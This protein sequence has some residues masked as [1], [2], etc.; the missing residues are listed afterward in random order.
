M[1]RIIEKLH[2]IEIG[3]SQKI[4]NVLRLALL[5]RARIEFRQ[6]LFGKASPVGIFQTADLPHIVLV[7]RR[8]ILFQPAA[9]HTL[10][11]AVY[12]RSFDDLFHRFL[13]E[14]G[15]ERRKIVVRTQSG[16]HRVV[17]AADLIGFCG[18]A[19]HDQIV[20]NAFF[21]HAA[22]FFFEQVFDQLL[23]Y[24]DREL[25]S[26]ETQRVQ[27]IE[28]HKFAVQQRVLRQHRRAGVGAFSDQVFQ[29]GRRA[30]V[31]IHNFFKIPR[32]GF[33]AGS[34]CFLSPLCPTAFQR[35]DIIRHT[36]GKHRFDL[37]AHG[38]A[39]L[40]LFEQERQIRR[41]VI[42]NFPQL[43]PVE[44]IR[45]DA[46]F[47]AGQPRKKRLLLDLRILR[48]KRMLRRRL[49]QHRLEERA[50][51]FLLAGLIPALRTV[52][53]V[54]GIVIRELRV[55]IEYAPVFVRRRFSHIVFQRTKV[56]MV[57]LILTDL[58]IAEI[59]FA[60][61]HFRQPRRIK[62][63]FCR[64]QQLH[65]LAQRRRESVK[66]GVQIVAQYDARR[67]GI[68]ERLIVIERSQLDFGPR[69]QI[70]QGLNICAALL[71]LHRPPQSG[72]QRRL[73]LGYAHI[74][75]GKDREVLRLQSQLHIHFR[76]EILCQLLHRSVYRRAF[77]AVLRCF[78]KE[79][80]AVLDDM[81][82]RQKY[83]PRVVRLGGMHQFAAQVVHRGVPAQIIPIRKI[84]VIE[85]RVFPG[86][87]CLIVRKE[88]AFMQPSEKERVR[89]PDLR[90]EEFFQIQKSLFSPLQTPAGNARRAP[91]RR[92]F[93]LLKQSR[94]PHGVS[95][96][97][98]NVVFRIGHRPADGI[99]A[100][101]KA[102]II[103]R[104]RSDRFFLF[105]FWLSSIDKFKNYAKNIDD[106]YYHLGLHYKFK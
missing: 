49:R 66:R 71:R 23:L 54:G 47:A 51:V 24:A 20:Q 15:D 68:F 5:I 105:H 3:V 62:H 27:L 58:C 104:M 106:P 32:V 25:V 93:C 37:L 86:S 33:L 73:L 29:K 18:I 45:D 36:E 30:R 76:R 83:E 101:V 97:A 98:Q 89:L 60:A 59:R 42:Q 53:A 17:N 34:L 81:V 1:L 52:A 84:R 8:E 4:Q 77:V 65:P 12:Q 99:C 88:R 40:V 78:I 63:F 21:R 75:V 56:G 64:K 48:C 7:Q 9:Q 74:A 87:G 28:K 6:K 67:F 61:A 82:Q 69:K 19:V 100:Y 10:V 72:A 55:F 50:K 41:C 26:V 85:K 44:L 13:A 96:E 39:V 90:R 70:G 14:H 57:F 80:P 38:D 94:A 43:L 35:P 11:V 16:L 79:M 92:R 46:V 31:E 2:E 22:V 95:L 102:D 103:R 91:V